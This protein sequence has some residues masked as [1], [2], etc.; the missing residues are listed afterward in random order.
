MHEKATR[1]V[2]L[3]SIEIDAVNA[4]ED[5]PRIQLETTTM[6][7]GENYLESIWGPQIITRRTLEKTAL[8]ASRRPCHPP[9]SSVFQSSIPHS[10]KSSTHAPQKS[11]PLYATISSGQL[12]IS[13]AIFNL[14][15]CSRSRSGVNAV[16]TANNTAPDFGSFLNVC[17]SRRTIMSRAFGEA[18]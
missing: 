17:R 16:F 9:S 11:L 5:H 2:R 7:A 8:K 15:S 3:E 4:S 14:S 1:G 6:N 12:R 18:C 10:M 13:R